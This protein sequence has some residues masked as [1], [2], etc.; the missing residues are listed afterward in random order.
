LLFNR[1]TFSWSSVP[2]ASGYT[3]QISKNILF[4][5][6]VTNTS[7]NGTFTS[8]TPSADL[9]ANSKLWWHVLATGP[10]GPSLWSTASFKSANPPPIPVMVSPANNA[11]STTYTPTLTWSQAALPSGTTFQDYELQVSTNSSFTVI[12]LD[13]SDLTSLGTPHYT[14]SSGEAFTP[15]T[16][17]YWHVRSFNTDNNLT[18]V[19][20]NSS[21]SPT[22]SLRTAVIPP[23]LAA[24]ADGLWTSNRRIPFS[25]S[26]VPT[27]TS[28]SLQVSPDANFDILT[29]NVTVNST[30]YT[31]TTNLPVGTLYWQVRANAANGPSAWSVTWSVVQQ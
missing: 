14:L 15:N 26:S 6:L 10:N 12:F 19:T 29:L 21:W 8:Y 1:P 17:Y 20:Y 27:A 3:I 18:G 23:T 30:T 31:P 24:P 7:G 22:W 13:H 5:Q 9:P 16:I 11:V 28:Y 4:T 25:W 2:G